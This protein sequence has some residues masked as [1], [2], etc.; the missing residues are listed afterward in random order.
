MCGLQILRWLQDSQPLLLKAACD[1]HALSVKWGR[2][3]E[4]VI[5]TVTMLHD[6]RSYAGVIK[7]RSQL[8]VD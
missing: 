2:Q 4:E 8:A 6:T 1:A 5:T 3:A 7:A